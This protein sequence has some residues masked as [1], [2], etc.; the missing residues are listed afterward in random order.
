MVVDPLAEQGRRWS[1][2]T[3][4]FDN[5]IRF[6]D[7]DGMWPFPSGPMISIFALEVKASIGAVFGIKAGKVG[8]EVNLGSK[9]IGS[10]SEDGFKKGEPG[11]KKGASIS[12]ALGEAKVEEK[13][14]ETTNETTQTLPG[15]FEIKGEKTVKT[16]TTTGEVSIAGFGVSREKKETTTTNSSIGSSSTSTEKSSK[17]EA[18]YSKTLPGTTQNLVKSTNFSV[19][20]GFKIDIE[21][22]LR[23]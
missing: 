10:V 20:A 7:P 21:V 6:I 18:K 12:Y 19:A 22:S 2:Y 3:Y 16:T 5:P 1:P 13:T 4:A 9:E 23:K 8:A 11:I 14:V 17:V 15:G